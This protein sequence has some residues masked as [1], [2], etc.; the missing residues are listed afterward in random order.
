MLVAIGAVITA[1]SLAAYFTQR[2]SR[3]KEIG[4]LKKD[5]ERFRKKRPAT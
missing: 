3:D 1:L 2:H 4:E 5:M